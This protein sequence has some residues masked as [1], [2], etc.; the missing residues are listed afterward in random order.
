MYKKNNNLRGVKLKKQKTKKRM[1]SD[2][3]R[4]N[5]ATHTNTHGYRD[6]RGTNAVTGDTPKHTIA[7]K[8]IKGQTSAHMRISGRFLCFLHS[9]SSTHFAASKSKDIQLKE[10]NLRYTDATLHDLKCFFKA[11]YICG[12]TPNEY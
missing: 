11:V 2:N 4:R 9:A 3:D 7:F 10:A 12:N 5:Q 6:T 1:L 8:Q